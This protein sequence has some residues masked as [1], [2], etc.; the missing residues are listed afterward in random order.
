MVLQNDPEIFQKTPIN[1][2]DYFLKIRIPGYFLFGC[3]PILF[4]LSSRFKT[5]RAIP[6]KPN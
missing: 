1:Y 5:K 2:Q 6:S 4:Q 3:Y